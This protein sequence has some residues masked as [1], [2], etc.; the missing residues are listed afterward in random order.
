M[1]PIRRSKSSR[2]RLLLEAKEVSGAR[3]TLRSEAGCVECSF[4]LTWASRGWLT[5]TFME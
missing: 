4:F 5:E 1:T 2:G 3:R